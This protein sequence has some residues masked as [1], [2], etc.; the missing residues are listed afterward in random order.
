M[1]GWSGASYTLTAVPLVLEWTGHVPLAGA[2]GDHGRHDGRAVAA[3]V[4]V[5][6]RGS[7][8]YR[9]YLLQIR[10]RVEGGFPLRESGQTDEEA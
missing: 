4:G 8:G 5:W 6:E 7:R 2:G 3:L 10:Q 1:H 9:V